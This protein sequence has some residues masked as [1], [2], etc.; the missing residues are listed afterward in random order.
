M[1]SVESSP[2]VEHRVRIR[3]PS[4]WAGAGLREL[5][6]FRE[7]LYFLAKRDLLVRYKQSVLGISWAVVQPVALTLIFSLIFGRLVKVPSQDVPYPL[8]ALSGFSAWI[9]VS[10]VV[11]QGGGS[12][13]ADANLLTKVY[14]PRIVIPIAKALALLVDLAVAIAVLIV[15]SLLY[16]RW[17]DLQALTLPL[18]LLLAMVAST[19]VAIFAAALNVRYRDVMAVLPLAIMIWLFLTPIAY[20]ASLVSGVWEYVYAVN[21]V[22]S[23]I[24]GV[25]WALLGTPG[26]AVVSVLVSCASALLMLVMGVV[27]FRRSEQYFADIV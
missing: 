4:R 27:Y 23:T 19:G 18:W 20:P 11:S 8:F 9:F 7:L 12:L 17:P 3:P 1:T 21:P 10:T 15:V 5:W 16:G 22:A 24:T 2:L 13:V 14:F 26:P 25:R 6:E